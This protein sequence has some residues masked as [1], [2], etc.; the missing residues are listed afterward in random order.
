[1]MNHNPSADPEQTGA[2]AS[3][4]GAKSDVDTAIATELAPAVAISLLAKSSHED[5]ATDPAL[6]C[7]AAG[8]SESDA[9]GM[10]RVSLVFENGAILPVE[11]PKEAGD[12]LAKG[13]QEDR[14]A[15]E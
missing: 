6:E 4:G 5:G 14:A 7:I 3:D 11:M 8:V 12:A 15:S 1:M 9:D 13:L 10:V 2:G